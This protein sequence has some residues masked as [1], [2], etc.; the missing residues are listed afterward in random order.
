MPRPPGPRMA[1]Q[2]RPPAVPMPDL[3]PTRGELPN[4]LGSQAVMGY[5][6]EGGG[7]G[8]HRT[9]RTSVATPLFRW[10]I[11]YW[12]R[13]RWSRKRRP[14]PA[15]VADHVVGGRVDDCSVRA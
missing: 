3:V 13:R 12:L 14:T 1:S 8:G 6:G 2:R 4:Q 5:R 10:D 7:R 9:L 15:G 11:V